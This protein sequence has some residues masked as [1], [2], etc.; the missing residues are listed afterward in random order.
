[1]WRKRNFTV[2][3]VSNITRVHILINLGEVIKVSS[4]SLVTSGGQ[5]FKYGEKTELGI[6]FSVSRS[7]LV[8][9]FVDFEGARMCGLM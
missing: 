2:I 6:V 4:P 9:L 8:H 3:S 1:M 5:V 7:T